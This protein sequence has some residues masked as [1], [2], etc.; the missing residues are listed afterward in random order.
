MNKTKAPE[1]EGITK[2]I[3]SDPIRL[4][5]LKGKVF[6]IEF[7]THSCGN[8]NNAIPHMQEIYEKY[9]SQGFV[10]IGVHSPELESDKNIDAI[11]SYCDQKKLTFPIAVDNDMMTWQVYGQQYWPTLYLIDKQGM[12]RNRHVGEGGYF[13]IQKEIE[14]L[15]EE[16]I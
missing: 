11:K 3:N 6:G 5:S 2:W 1:L 9:R 7:W 10:L 8:C 4:E 16:T 14:H 13:A 12:V 15:L